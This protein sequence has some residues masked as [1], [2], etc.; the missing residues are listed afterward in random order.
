MIDIFTITLVT[1]VIVGIIGVLALY[2]LV[3][4]LF[5]ASP[6]MSWM[7][8]YALTA[9][10]SFLI[11]WGTGGYYYVIKYGPDVKPI[12]KAGTNPWAHG[13]FMEAKEHIFLFLPIITFVILLALWAFGDRAYQ[14]DKIKRSL[15]LLAITAFILSIFITASG[16]I[17]SGSAK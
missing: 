11:S 6:N 12:I 4:S 7:R 3:M 15:L 17:I 2:M 1:H 14:D 8:G 5:R 13:V 10:L 16:I 9:F